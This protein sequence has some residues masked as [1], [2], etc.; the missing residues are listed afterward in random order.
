[1]SKTQEWGFLHG[2]PG[3]L[4]LDTQS[5]LFPVGEASSHVS[6]VWS[7]LRQCSQS[8][9]HVFLPTADSPGVIPGIIGAVVMAVVGAVSSFIAYQKKK[10]CFKENSKVFAAASFPLCLT[11]LKALLS[12][13]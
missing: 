2:H 12:R 8:W 10:L 6:C 11:N 9:F 4:C 1:M 3:A 7:A 5:H 13:N